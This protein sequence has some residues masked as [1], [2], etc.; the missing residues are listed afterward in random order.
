L[1]RAAEAIDMDPMDVK[2]HI[3]RQTFENKIPKKITE[4]SDAAERVGSAMA[5]PR[6]RLQEFNAFMEME[7]ISIPMSVQQKIMLDPR[8]QD[9]SIPLKDL[10]EE[11][12]GKN[13]D[14]TSASADNAPL[15]DNRLE[16]IPTGPERTP[17]MRYG[18][19]LPD[20]PDHQDGGVAV[21]LKAM[22]EKERNQ[23]Q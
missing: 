12:L 6:Y 20:L 13:T 8:F 16:D 7:G 14:T 18:G 10:I 4:L 2:E 3:A 19:S 5:A 1:Q 22:N 11:Y 17:Q 21:G 23:I 9:G 15:P